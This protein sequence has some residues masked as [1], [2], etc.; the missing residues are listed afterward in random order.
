MIPNTLRMI[1][2]L[3]AGAVLFS[4]ANPVIRDVD[5]YLKQGDYEKAAGILEQAGKKRPDD[6]EILMLL[7][8]CHGELEHYREFRDILEN[9][10]LDS[11]QYGRRVKFIREKYWRINYNRAVESL[12]KN[13]LEEAV[14]FLENAILVD[15]GKAES[16]ALLGDTYVRLDRPDKAIEAYAHHIRIDKKETVYCENVAKLYFES[17]QY[18]RSVELAR[19][20]LRRDPALFSSYLRLAFAYQEMDSLEAAEA[21]YKNALK[22]GQSVL[23]FEEYGK[24]CYRIKDYESA[25][26]QFSQGL[27]LSQYADRFYKYLA[28][29]CFGLND[30]KNVAAYYE[31]YLSSRNDDIEAMKNLL[32]AYDRLGDTLNYSRIRSLLDDGR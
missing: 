11:Y 25:K 13:K 17:G 14:G 5:I 18:S 16:Y 19:E 26:E 7:A 1:C 3:F 4:C 12:T 24:F 8:E 22:L 30:F 32:I 2:M 15:N 21:A 9:K 27:L 6:G 31:K 20:A 23:L 10:I 29:C 28:E